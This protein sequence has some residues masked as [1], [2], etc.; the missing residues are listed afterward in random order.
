MYQKDARF[1]GRIMLVDNDLLEYFIQDPSSRM[2]NR[3]TTD[4][5]KRLA[6]EYNHFEDGYNPGT[7]M[8]QEKLFEQL[9]LKNKFIK[10]QLS[11]EMLADVQH[12]VF[13][14]TKKFFCYC[15]DNMPK[16]GA[17]PKDV[18]EC[19]HRDC[20]LTYFHKS[21]V[22]KLGV[23]KVSR[24]LCT[25]CEENMR[26]LAYRTLRKLGYDDVPDDEEDLNNSFEN[27]Q[28]KYNLSDAAMEKMRI[29]VD[30]MGGG[31]RMAGVVAMAMSRMN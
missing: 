17:A 13:E 6:I 7:L 20:K 30:A 10:H 9:W 24:W 15:H 14:H 28:A 29:R 25:G 19:T 11:S 4:A 27:L 21:C 22:K 16:G 3:H 1:K 8:H 5:P 31:F 12:G 23:A 18:V 26:S 2:A